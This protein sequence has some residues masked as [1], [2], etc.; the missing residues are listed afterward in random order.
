MKTV[1]S[2]IVCLFVS[3]FMSCV[4]SVKSPVSNSKATPE[5]KQLFARL[6]KLQDKGI[7]YGHQDDLMTGNTHWYEPGS[8]DTK[9]AVGDYPAVAGFELGEIETGH[10]RSLDS[11]SFAQITEQVKDFHK[12][13]GIITISWHVINPITSQYSGKK[14]PNGFGS[15]WD[16]QT[17]SADGMNAIKTILPGGE[18]NEMFN[19]W[20]TTLSDYFLTW[21]DDNG[22]LIPFLFRPYHEHSGSFFWWGD[23]RCT[24]E[25]YASLWRYTVDFLREKGLH[26][27]LF[28]YNTDKVYSVEQYLKGYPGDEYIDM[29]S[30]DWYGQGKEFNK[31]VDEGL[32]FTTQLAQEKNKLHALSECGPLSLD[33]QKILKKYKTSYVLTWRNAPKSPSVPNFGYLLRAMSDDPQYLFLQDIQ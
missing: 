1:N 30:I 28:V 16:V 25:E 13:N 18:N 27:I 20:L 5:A 24:D 31:V 22:R 8:S 7:M 17:L 10:E 21:T 19:Q 12:K 11:I 14:S 15:A 3:L 33:L 2:I 26:N 23:T 32:A 4:E 9:D 6:Q 29:I